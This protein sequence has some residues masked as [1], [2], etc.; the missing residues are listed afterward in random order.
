[1]WYYGNTTAQLEQNSQGSLNETTEWF[2][3]EIH[4]ILALFSPDV[5]CQRVCDELILSGG[6]GR[7]VAGHVCQ[8]DSSPSASFFSLFLPLDLTGVVAV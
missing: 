5:V 8:T 2:P 6:R 4:L 1:M 3:T 7:G